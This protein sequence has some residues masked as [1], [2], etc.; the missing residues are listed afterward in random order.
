M[1]DTTIDE[2][3]FKNPTV[4]P[5]FN[6]VKY[7]NDRNVRFPNCDIDRAWLLDQAVNREL[8]K[9]GRLSSPSTRSIDREELSPRKKTTDRFKGVDLK[10]L[11]QIRSDLIKTIR[12]KHPRFIF[13]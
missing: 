10:D 8:K 1:S 12:E 3:R 4:I 13:Q 6:L 7:A 11:T 2:E 9:M 5:K